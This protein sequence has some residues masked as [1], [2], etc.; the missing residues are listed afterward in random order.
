M[1]HIGG[2]K[3]KLKV[4]SEILEHE[5]KIAKECVDR[6]DAMIV[7][8]GAWDG[9]SPVSEVKADGLLRRVSVVTWCVA[10]LE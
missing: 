2:T 10:S 9:G 1:P 3:G 5:E 6:V 7:D 8:E 4:G